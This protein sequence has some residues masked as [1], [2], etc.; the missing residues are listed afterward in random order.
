MF[1]LVPNLEYLGVFSIDVACHVGRNS[2]LY[3]TSVCVCVC[4]EMDFPWSLIGLWDGEDAGMLVIA[5]Y[6]IH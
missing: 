2:G 1:L 3:A 5:G 6:A 4:V